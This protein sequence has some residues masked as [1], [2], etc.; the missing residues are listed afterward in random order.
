[1]GKDSIS[2]LHSCGKISEW[3]LTS[4]L[5]PMLKIWLDNRPKKKLNLTPSPEFQMMMKMTLLLQDLSQEDQLQDHL[6]SHKT[7]AE[8]MKSRRTS[9]TTTCEQSSFSKPIFQNYIKS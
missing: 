2:V 1:M 8:L 4:M 9:S 7:T 6:L 3:R 5:M